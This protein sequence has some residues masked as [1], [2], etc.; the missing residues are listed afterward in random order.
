M[1]ITLFENDVYVLKCNDFNT[2]VAAAD[3]LP[4]S[5]SFIDM[6]GIDHG[7]FLVGIGSLDTATTLA[8]YEDT[9]ATETA[10]IQAV[11]GA[12]QAVLDTDDDKWMSIEFNANQISRD[13][14]YRYVTLVSS[15]GA[16]GNDYFCVFFLGFKN[17]VQPVTQ[18]TD[19]AYHVSVVS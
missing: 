2:A 4:A 18:E 13:D 19:Y 14:G 11:T 1:S 9:S 15:A 7:V 17:R 10:D 12:S 16:G 3:R 8:V 5:G 6:A